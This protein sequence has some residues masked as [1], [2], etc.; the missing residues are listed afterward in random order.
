MQ[1][2]KESTEL[3]ISGMFQNIVPRPF[4]KKGELSQWWFTSYIYNCLAYL[5]ASPF[6]SVRDACFRRCSVDIH[7]NTG[8]PGFLNCWPEAL[9][10]SAVQVA[11]CCSILGYDLLF[12]KLTAVYPVYSPLLIPI[13]L[14]CNHHWSL[15]H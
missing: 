7:M 14:S 6:R 12:H 8:F 11:L 10:L 5:K 2:I 4:V 3:V 15:L 13:L 1:S 9:K